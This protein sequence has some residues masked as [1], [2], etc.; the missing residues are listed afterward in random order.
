M[1]EH[2]E[3]LPEEDWDPDIVEALTKAMFDGIGPPP[4]PRVTVV[5]TRGHDDHA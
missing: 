3:D 4:G 5:G 1:T 2:P